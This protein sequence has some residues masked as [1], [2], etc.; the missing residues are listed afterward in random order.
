MGMVTRVDVVTRVGVV[1]KVGVITIA[2]GGVV[3]HV[4]IA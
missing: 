1:T 2:L 4:T 3:L